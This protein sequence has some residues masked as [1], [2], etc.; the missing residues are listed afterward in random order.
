MYKISKFTI[1]LL[2]FQR[3]TAKIAPSCMYSAVLIHNF[4]QTLL[5]L[6][7]L[8]LLQKRNKN[9]ITKL[10]LEE[11]IFLRCQQSRL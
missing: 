1:T 7:L 6:L 9:L 4:L 11:A 3:P 8:L 10:N 5:K 2:I